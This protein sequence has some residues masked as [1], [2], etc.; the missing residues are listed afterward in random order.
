MSFNIPTRFDP[1][2]NDPVLTE[3]EAA[4]RAGE[5]VVN[6]GGHWVR[7]SE[8]F[9]LRPRAVMH[10]I[11]KAPSTGERH[12]ILDSEVE[13]RTVELRAEVAVQKAVI[14]ELARRLAIKMLPPEA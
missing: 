5:P 6:M 11:G 8:A 7:Q 9:P 4:A 2:G 3:A 1:L 12:F 14:D 13:R 10:A